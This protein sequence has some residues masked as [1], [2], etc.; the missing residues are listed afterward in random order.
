MN[1]RAEG[2]MEVEI[3]N[4]IEVGNEIEYI[5]PQNKYRFQISAMES[6][7]GLTLKLAHGGNG[8]VWIKTEGPIDPYAL[9]SRVVDLPVSSSVP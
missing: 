1:Q 2:W 7:S 8:T 4:R 3:K 5:S 9:L 6:E